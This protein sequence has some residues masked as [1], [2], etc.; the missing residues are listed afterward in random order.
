MLI[1]FGHFHAEGPD[2]TVLDKAM[3]ALKEF[4]DATEDNEG[5]DELFSTDSHARTLTQTRA[6]TRHAHTRGS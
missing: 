4:Y 2:T 1:Y 5:K 6:C 3:G